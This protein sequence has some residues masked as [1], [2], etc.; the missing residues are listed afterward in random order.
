MPSAL[1]WRMP[2]TLQPLAAPMPMPSKA[3]VVRALGSVPSGSDGSLTHGE[4]CGL[5]ES[6]ML[7]SWG[8]YSALSLGLFLCRT[9][10]IVP[11]ALREVV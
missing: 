11:G 3:V 4:E 8:G 1:R 5:A 2:G 10:L 7:E 9:R 6:M